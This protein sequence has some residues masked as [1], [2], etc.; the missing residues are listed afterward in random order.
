M[1]TTQD[2]SSSSSPPNSSLSSVPLPEDDSKKEIVLKPAAMKLKN[3]RKN[4][5][6]RM[7][8]KAWRNVVCIRAAF[9]EI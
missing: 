5:E 6:K 7:L 1:D 3:Q 4:K 2:C 8:R 9:Y